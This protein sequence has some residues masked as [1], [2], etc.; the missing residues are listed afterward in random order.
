MPG[1]T[2]WAWKDSQGLTAGVIGS[3]VVGHRW[4]DNKADGRRGER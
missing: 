4:V 1:K 3:G 2:R